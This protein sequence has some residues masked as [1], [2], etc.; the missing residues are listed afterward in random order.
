MPLLKVFVLSKEIIGS[1][2]MSGYLSR[3]ERKIFQNITFYKY[4]SHRLFF[5]LFA[6]IGRFYFIRIY[7]AIFLLDIL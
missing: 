6:F 1:Y 5:I 3:R 7:W 4:C 2:Y